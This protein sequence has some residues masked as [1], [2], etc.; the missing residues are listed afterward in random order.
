VRVIVSQSACEGTGYCQQLCPEVF[1][2]GPDGKAVADPAAAAAAS[3]DDLREAERMCPTSA[4]RIDDTT[5]G[6]FT[7]A[8]TG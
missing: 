6:P 2:A 4:I 3:P 5:D 1:S 8:G 7:Q